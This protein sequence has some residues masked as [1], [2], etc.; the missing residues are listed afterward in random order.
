MKVA[1]IA[2]VLDDDIDTDI[3][4]PGR[5]LAVLKP[6]EQA[7]HLFERLG[8]TLGQ[9]VS[10]GGVIVAGWKFGCG[11][12]REHAASALT[13]RITDPREVLDPARR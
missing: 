7:R 1:G 5:Y 11:S 8:E 2:T 13:G 12:S 9:Q 3:I 4:F 6:Q 10:G